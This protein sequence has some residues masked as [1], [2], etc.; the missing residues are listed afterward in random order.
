MNDRFVERLEHAIARGLEKR[1]RETDDE[2][3]RRRERSIHDGG[4]V[5][6]CGKTFHPVRRN[7]VYCSKR[8]RDARLR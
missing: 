1:P 7:Q 6:S 4:R 8:C 3:Q 5:C 2:V